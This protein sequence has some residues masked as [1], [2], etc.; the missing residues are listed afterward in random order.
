MQHNAMTSLFDIADAQAPPLT[1]GALTAQI[2]QTL[3]T[4]FADVH[5]VGEISNLSRPSSGH[6]YFN[7]KDSQA[8]IRAVVW[9]SSVRR[10]KADLENGLEVIARGK[11]SVYP[12]RG[13]YQLILDDVVPKG[14]GAQDIALR[15][16]MEKLQKLGY[17]AAERK[18]PIPKFPRRIALVTSPSGAAIR[19]ML[20]IL[21]RRWPTA[22]VLVGPVRVQGEGAAEDIA[23]MLTTIGRLLGIDVVILGRGGGG[24]D[25]LSAFNDERVAHAIFQCKLPII[26]AVGH[27]I[28]VTIADL[29]ADRRALTPSEAAEIATPDRIELAKH[30]GAR[31]QRLFDLAINRVKRWR[32]RLDEIADR[33]VFRQPLERPRE[34]ERKLDEI[35]QRMRLAFRG[36][37]ELGNARMAALAGKLESL[38][39]LNVL[40]RGYSLTRVPD[41]KAIV[42]SVDDV[43]V[44][45]VVEVL[46]ADGE[47]TATVNSTRKVATDPST[48]RHHGESG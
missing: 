37:I 39:P 5:I 29:V 18:K 16:L 31:A 43:A 4:G 2:Q 26:S 33:R 48:T 20:E 10:L 38:S 3:E 25:D 7:L 17:F 41:D 19:D 12:P 44:G 30:I 34:L 14:L 42:R 27:E 21:S 8:C 23:R 24:K 45:D 22:E 40:S 11:I 1:V 46:L 13:D 15:K 32:Q 47:L 35:D 28:D 6:L 9:R 36:R